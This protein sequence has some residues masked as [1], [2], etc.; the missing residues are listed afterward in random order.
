MTLGRSVKQGFMRITII[1]T[2]VQSA[3]SGWF[4]RNF[5]IKTPAFCIIFTAIAV[6]SDIFLLGLLDFTL[7]LESFMLI[8]RAFRLIRGRFTAFL[9][10]LVAETAFF[11]LISA[12]NAVRFAHSRFQ[13]ATIAACLTSASVIDATVLR[14]HSKYNGKNTS[15]ILIPRGLRLFYFLQLKIMQRIDT[16]VTIFSINTNSKEITSLSNNK[17]P[18]RAI[19]KE[20][21][22]NDIITSTERQKILYLSDR[23]LRV[24]TS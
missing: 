4:L 13:F 6:F 9:S 16:Q 17:R 8:L 1:A 7:S 20:I 10:S 14:T 12:I 5:S 3:I 19:I 22:T 2:K 15:P 23:S 21:R 18:I 11:S 24:V